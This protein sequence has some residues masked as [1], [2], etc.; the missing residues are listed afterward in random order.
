MAKGNLKGGIIIG[1]IVLALVVA[2]LVLYSGLKKQSI[3]ET[4]GLGSYEVHDNATD[5][6]GSKTVTTTAGQVFS[7]SALIPG[8]SAT[9]TAVKKI[10]NQASS[11]IYTIM[12]TVVS[13]TAN[14]RWEIQ[15][16]Q[17]FY[18][19]T[20]A[21]SGGNLPLVSEI[22]WFSV[23]DHSRGNSQTTSFGNTTST[24]FYTWNNP[25][26]GTGQTVIL[27][28]LNY[29]CL[30]LNMSGSSTEAWIQLSTR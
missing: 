25:M 4:L 6:F 2:S 9:S 11:A 19:E 5:V 24:E 26:A 10:G 3:P 27:E 1:G 22:N 7:V 12:P 21:T 14:L 13:S 16:S 20:T 18:C 30:R 28:N 17:D 23:G 29:E 8:Q 15:G